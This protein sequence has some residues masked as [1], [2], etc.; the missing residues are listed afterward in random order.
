MTCSCTPQ[1]PLESSLENILCFLHPTKCLL[2]VLLYQ[3]KILI[4]HIELSCWS[5]YTPAQSEDPLHTYPAI[6]PYPGICTLLG[7]DS[8]HWKTTNTVD[9]R[10]DSMTNLLEIHVAKWGK[11]DKVQCPREIQGQIIATQFI[12]PQPEYIVYIV[13]SKW[14]WVKISRTYLKKKKKRWKNDDGHRKVRVRNFLQILFI[15]PDFR[16]IESS[17][18]MSKMS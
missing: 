6:S 8:F 13:Y 9:I 15:S 18:Y 14:S 10:T 5:K 12:C 3:A 16:S 2:Y 1:F 4:H 17:T 11:K 7:L